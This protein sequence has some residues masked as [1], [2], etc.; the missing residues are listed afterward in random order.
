MGMANNAIHQPGL[1]IKIK[2]LLWTITCGF[3]TI[4]DEQCHLFEVFSVQKEEIKC[5][6]D[7]KESEY[8]AL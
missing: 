1:S 4:L 5:E 2:T 6:K 8:R 3:L 7:Q